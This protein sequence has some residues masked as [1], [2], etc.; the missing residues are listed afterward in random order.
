M[1]KIKTNFEGQIVYSG[2]DIQK[3]VG[4]WEFS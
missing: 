4:T 3:E 2:M 1:N